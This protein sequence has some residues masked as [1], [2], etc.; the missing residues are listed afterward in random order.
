MLI[1]ADTSNTPDIKPKIAF[2]SP[3]PPADDVLSISVE[4]AAVFA[5]NGGD[6]S[7]IRANNEGVPK[8]VQHQTSGQMRHSS[9]SPPLVLIIRGAAE[10]NLINMV[11]YLYDQVSLLFFDFLV[12]LLMFADYQAFP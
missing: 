5:P 10:P 7:E 2:P 12:L 9:I 4:V 6:F 8:G 3:T 11:D 1:F